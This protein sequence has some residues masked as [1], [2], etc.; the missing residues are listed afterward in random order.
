MYVTSARSA[1]I[2]T[3]TIQTTAAARATK[4]W[5]K[6]MPERET[7][8]QMARRISD[9]LWEESREEGVVIYDDDAHSGHDVLTA[10]CELALAEGAY[11]SAVEAALA[12]ITTFRS[13]PLLHGVQARM[14]DRV[15]AA[16]ARLKEM[17]VVR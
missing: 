5:R 16:L 12:E 11:Q 6:T 10:L 7:K 3:A 9:I 13:E 8:E 1:T 17:G 14:G 15:V 4:K 2:S